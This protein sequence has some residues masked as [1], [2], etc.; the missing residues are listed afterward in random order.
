MWPR[1]IP[2]A[3]TTGSSARSRRSVLAAAGAAGAGLAGCIEGLVE[4]TRFGTDELEV[5]VKTLPSDED[6]A[7]A[8]VARRLVEHLEAVGMDAGLEPKAG[9]AL[10]RD[11]LVDHDFEVV[12]AQFPGLDDPDALRPL[13]HSSFVDET[14]WQN[15]FGLEAA[16]VDGLLDRQRTAT[17]WRR[18]ELVFE[19]QHAILDHVPFAV[20][21]AP[22]ELTAL[23]RDLPDR[24]RPTGLADPMDLLA[25]E[26]EDPEGST[27]RVGLLDGR[28]TVDRNPL[29]PAFP[30]QRLVVGLVYDPLVRWIDGAYRPWGASD[31]TWLDHGTH[32]V[33]EVTLPAA[34]TWHDGEAV[35]A[36]DVAFT[37]RY[38]RDL[39]LG[40]ANEAMPAP[41]YRGR[42]SMVDDVAAIDERTVRVRFDRASRPL[43]RRALSVPV[44]PAHRWSAITGL[45]DGR[46]AALADPNRPT[47]GAG[48]MLVEESEPGELLAL[49]RN[50]RHPRLVGTSVGTPPAPLLSLDRVAFEVPT[51]PPTIGSAVNRLADDTL[52]AVA[53]VPAHR[54]ATVIRSPAAELVVRP[55][56]QFYLVGY[57]LRG[58]PGSDPRFRR[59]VSRLIDRTFVVASVFR[60]FAAP[61]DS[62]LVNTRYLDP[63]LAW[64]GE[65]ALGG[66][67]GTSGLL[68]GE[69][70]RRLF[71]EAGFEYD[72]RGTLIAP[73]SDAD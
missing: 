29:T 2:L 38:L 32:P 4:G 72:E 48:P 11:V 10:S 33:A 57:N 54:A 58:P 64:D 3:M 31:V 42:V 70:A 69:A 66:F 35:T 21:A 49:A 59:L 68:D 8:D 26:P 40:S 46:P 12:V 51:S 73:P 65:S 19:L 17:G 7:A 60:G 22:D 63:R 13:L 27:L 1:P 41:R 62:P 55:S 71:R 39:T 56:T 15:P 9:E 53:R 14:G 67:P 47:V 28:I 5:T 18:D 37:Y 52:D 6:P 16:A 61:A 43:A 50:D 23:R 25:L 44:L 34:Y 45:E 30:N 36:A 24:T 20:V